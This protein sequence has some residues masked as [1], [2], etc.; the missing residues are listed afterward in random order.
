M[1][2]SGG[3]DSWLTKGKSKQREEVKEEENSKPAAAA[4]TTATAKETPSKKRKAA[5]KPE[6]TL[7]TR[8]SARTK[9]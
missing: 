8:K 1:A 4:T 2:E 9:K 3:F 5:V 6:P 7:G